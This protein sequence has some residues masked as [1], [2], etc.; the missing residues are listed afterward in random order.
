[1]G[2][3][4][5]KR[6]RIPHALNTLI[7][8]PSSKTGVRPISPRAHGT[9]PGAPTSLRSRRAWIREQ[10]F[11]FHNTGAHE[12]LRTQPC[13]DRS[14]HR[15]LPE[16]PPQAR[17]SRYRCGILLDPRRERRPDHR[18]QRR[19]QRD[20]VQSR[21]RSAAGPSGRRMVRLINRRGSVQEP[22][23]VVAVPMLHGLDMSMLTPRARLHRIADG[24]DLQNREMIRE[25]KG[26]QG[27]NGE[28]ENSQPLSPDGARSRSGTR[29][30]V[31]ASSQ[32]RLRDG[33]SGPV[34]MPHPL[35][36]GAAHNVLGSWCRRR[37][38]ARS[39]GLLGPNSAPGTSQCRY[40]LTVGLHG[41]PDLLVRWRVDA[42]SPRTGPENSR[43][44]P[45]GKLLGSTSCP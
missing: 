31:L 34:S 29:R 9:P 4:C 22:P 23:G 28:E 16:G 8:G 10:P 1:M 21:P 30:G 2:H 14:C 37:S 36:V 12:R 38:H 13:R 11:C 44:P 18:E 39:V 35:V 17:P 25:R 33:D 42:P 41:C 27:E 26:E 15:Q 5:I 20:R 40:S 7:Y 6:P 19:R 24:R 32:P 3:L 45:C 43:R